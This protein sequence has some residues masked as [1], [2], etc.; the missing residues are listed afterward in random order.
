[1]VA[2]RTP[3]LAPL[4]SRHSRS[5]TQAN[6]VIAARH[7]PPAT[8][9]HPRPPPHSA[10][11]AAVSIAASS[12]AVG[13]TRRS[14]ATR[15]RRHWPRAPLAA[16]SRARPRCPLRARTRGDGGEGWRRGSSALICEAEYSSPRP[17]H[18]R[19]SALPP[20]RSAAR[21]SGSRWMALAG[22]TDQFNWHARNPS[23]C[24]R[25]D[26][27]GCV[28][29]RRCSCRPPL[30]T[31]ATRPAVP[32]APRPQPSR[33]GHIPPPHAKPD[34]HCLAASLP[35]H[36]AGHRAGHCAGHR[37]ARRLGPPAPVLLRVRLQ[38]RHPQLPQLQD[39][40]AWAALVW[41][42]PCA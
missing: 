37:P 9:R 8:Y 40:W 18:H 13:R 15:M 12:E 5:A 28:C 19:Y 25:Y 20:S 30:D 24:E 3:S 27:V 22:F 23:L 7:T 11:T 38:V 16:R 39:G 29:S 21:P 6:A 41:V 17:S 42:G 10:R 4:H 33:R 34:V 32:T 14:H 2:R 36:V 35:M 31:A 1:M 26:C